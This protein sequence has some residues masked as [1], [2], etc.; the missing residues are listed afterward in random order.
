M[1]A[2]LIEVACKRAVL[3][4][5]AFTWGKD[6]CCT[7]V[8]DI[9]LAD[10]GM[11]LMASLRGSYHNREGAR[12]AWGDGGFVACVQGLAAQ[13]GL[14]RVDFPFDGADLGLVTTPMGPVLAVFLDGSWFGR[15]ESGFFRF[16]R[17]SGFLAWRFK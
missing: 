1:D 3:P 12:A 11:D 17:G 15:S 13:S 9:A 4:S 14:I 10:K 7:F 6:D 16:P 2:K 5:N 8:C